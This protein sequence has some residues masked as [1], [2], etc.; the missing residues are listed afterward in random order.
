[1]YD[2]LIRIHIE[3]SAYKRKRKKYERYPITAICMEWY[4]FAVYPLFGV[5]LLIMKQKRYCRSVSMMMMTTMREYTLKVKISL[6]NLMAKNQIEPIKML[7][8]TKTLQTISMDA[9]HDII[10]KKKNNSFTYSV[11]F[12]QYIAVLFL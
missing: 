7:A 1:M 2:T 6:R 4:F 5:E 12:F 3:Y 9:T 10:D 8:N 11:H